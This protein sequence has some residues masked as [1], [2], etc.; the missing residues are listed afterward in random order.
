LRSH[1]MVGVGGRKL[2][3]RECGFVEGLRLRPMIQP[4]LDDLYAISQG[5]VLPDLAQI[6]VALRQHSV[7]IPHL[8]AVPVDVEEVWV[9]GLPH[10]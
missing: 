2:T 3:V 4:L 8:M 1:F 7:L 10:P 5:A 6:L 9:S